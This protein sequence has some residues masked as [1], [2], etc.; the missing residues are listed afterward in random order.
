MNI[1]VIQKEGKPEW[2]VIPYK[3]YDRLIK[4][5]ELL[6]DIRDYDLAKDAIKKGE[7]LIPSEVTYAILDG[8]N[9]I[10]IWRQHRSF[11]QQALAKTAGIS[12]AYLS[13]LES[14]AR[15]GTTQVLKKLAKA[16]DISLDDL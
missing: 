1:Q 3:E 7:E 4:N 12:K 14:G 2:A 9:P 13:Q 8:K 11:S 5:S 16:L 15:Q 6:R 10:K